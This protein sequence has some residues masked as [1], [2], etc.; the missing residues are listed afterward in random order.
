MNQYSL[1]QIYYALISIYYCPCVYEDVSVNSCISALF[2]MGRPRLRGLGM[3]KWKLFWGREEQKVTAENVSLSMESENCFN[4]FAA[5]PP[6]IFVR[7][8]FFQYCRKLDNTL[9]GHCWLYT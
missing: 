6:I 3:M 4:V 2:S 7:V 1:L 8:H 9:V 5:N